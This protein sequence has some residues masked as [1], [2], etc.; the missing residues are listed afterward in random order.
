MS[1]NK[2]RQYMV[3][4]YGHQPLKGLTKVSEQPIYVA[5]ES[6]KVDYYD[7]PWHGT[8][9]GYNN[10]GCRCDRCVEAYRA[11]NREKYNRKKKK[12]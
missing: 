4:Y 8:Y 9:G 1:G 3:K 10:N 7:E 6:N 2:K 11:Y 12:K 5:K